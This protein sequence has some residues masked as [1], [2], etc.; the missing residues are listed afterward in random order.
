MP[1]TETPIILLEGV[2]KSFGRQKVLDGVNLEIVTGKTTV[3]IGESGQGKSLI[4]KHI[5]GLLT[6][7]K[8]RVVVG[9]KNLA[10]LS[11]RELREVRTLFGVLFQGSALFDSLTVYDNIALPLRERTN[12]SEAEIHRRVQ[13]K[14]EMMGLADSD[15][16]Y[17]A[18][19]SGGMIKRVG[20]AR[21]LQLEPKIVLFDE[22]TTGLDPA[23]SSEMYTLFYQ[24]QKK[25][26]YTAVIVSHDVP[27]IFKL[28]DY[29]A[30]LHNG[31][32]REYLTP[33][34]IPFSENPLI[35]SFVKSTMG[36]VYTSEREE[37]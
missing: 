12:L 10:E 15:N 11:K 35:R 26:G 3:I 22:P 33:D 14:L 7:D 27:K 25:L 13:E 17:P 5:L 24:A 1:G 30:V 18:Q 36:L 20:L 21:A 23:K 16:K 4:L 31:R 19:L 37:A 29:V 6:P 8:G 34:R 28:A 32:I 2:E 9:G